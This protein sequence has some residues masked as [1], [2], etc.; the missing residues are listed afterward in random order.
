MSNIEC[1]EK[2]IGFVDIL[3][4]EKLGSGNTYIKCWI[5]MKGD[6]GKVRLKPED[7]TKPVG[8]TYEIIGGLISAVVSALFL[9]F[10]GWLGY[11]A[12]VVGRLFELPVLIITT[13]SFLL[14]LGFFGIAHKL[15]SGDANKNKQLLTN[16][17]LN[18]MGWFFILMSVV[19]SID[20]MYHGTPGG[21][22]VRPAFM[23]LTGFLMGIGS[24]RLAKQRKSA[25]SKSFEQTRDMRP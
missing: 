22:Y 12:Y 25:A 6:Q 9:I 19:L 8:R 16:F 10:A 2:F 7:Y 17:T 3:G 14:F 20:F 18:F 23:L 15:I 24:L 4:W 1:K 21:D 5:L 13:I 11:S